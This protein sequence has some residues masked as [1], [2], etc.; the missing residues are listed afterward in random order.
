[1]M[2]K[3]GGANGRGWIDVSMPLRG[4][5]ARWPGDPGFRLRRTAEIASGDGLNLSRLEM[6]A[7]VGTHVDA[8]LHFLAEGE[9][10]DR[11][12]PELM[13]GRARVVL[14]EDPESVKPSD[15]EHLGIRRGERVLLKTRNSDAPWTEEPFREDFVYLSTE[16]AAFLAGAGVGLVGIDYLSVGGYRKNEIDVHRVLLSAGVW[17]VEGLNL[18]EATSGF[19]EL[20]CLPL[21][22]P[23][24]D[25][26]PARALIRP[27][28]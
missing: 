18:M 10:I 12:P 9:G 19:C 26:A 5:M 15:L 27:R 13:A 21:R 17:V 1:M 11:M 24:G 20:L 14:I 4:G 23:G 3:P 22:I 6:S 8:P 28:E 2:E 16:G 25:G 7:H